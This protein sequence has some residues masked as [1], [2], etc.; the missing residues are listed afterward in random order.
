[1]RTSL[2]ARRTPVVRRGNILCVKVLAIVLLVAA[3]GAGALAAQQPAPAAG[4]ATVMGT[5]FDSIRL[6]PMQ[7]ARVRVDTSQMFGMVDAEGRFRIEN[8]PAGTH[9]LRVEHPL[10]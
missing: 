7:G 3:S 10:L 6:R 2:S 1:M 4:T 8:V 5:V 9:Q